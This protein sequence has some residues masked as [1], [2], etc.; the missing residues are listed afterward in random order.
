MFGY[1][2]M[3]AGRG[4]VCECGRSLKIMR[5]RCEDW[6]CRRCWSSRYTNAKVAFF[7]ISSSEE[8]KDAMWFFKTNEYWR[9]IIQQMDT[10]T[11]S[12]LT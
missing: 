9:N 1:N 6:M 10:S 4:E 7:Y 2:K 3:P 12:R 5:A 11:P 8:S